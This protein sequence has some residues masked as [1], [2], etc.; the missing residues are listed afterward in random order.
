MIK[1]KSGKA[2]T[3]VAQFKS[4]Q[5]TNRPEGEIMDLILKNSQIIF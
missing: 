1:Y 2:K 5:N 4:E 3:R